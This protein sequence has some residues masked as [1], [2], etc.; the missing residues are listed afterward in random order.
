M[1]ACLAL[2]GLGGGPYEFGDLLDRLRGRSIEVR[3]PVLPGHEG[4]GPFMG[5]AGWPEWTGLAS[6]AFESLARI[7]R[8]VSVLGFS[9]GATLAL[10]LASRYP[11]DRLVLMA[12]FLGVRHLARLPVPT[13]R[14][15]RGIARILPHVPRRT[16]AVRDRIGRRAIREAEAFRTFSLRATVSALELIQQV[17]PTVPSIRTPTLILQGRHDSVV[18]PAGASWLYDHLGSPRKQLRWLERS[19]HL[20]A[21][22]HDR[23]AAADLADDW[24]AGSP[25]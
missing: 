7:G 12:P 2:H 22:D 1:S 14:Y 21:L 24:L 5:R 3:A 9:T 15:L 11:V 18:D 13:D 6:E 10:W 16:P 25:S 19:D 23:E 8:P 17:K 4:P 20:I